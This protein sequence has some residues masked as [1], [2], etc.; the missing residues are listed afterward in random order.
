MIIWKSQVFVSRNGRNVPIEGAALK[1]AYDLL[2]QWVLKEKT[3]IPYSTLMDS[4]KAKNHR[5]I[6][7]GSIGHIVGHIS[8]QVAIATMPKSIY[9]SSIVVLKGTCNTGDGF[10]LVDEGSNPPS[11]IASGAKKKALQT[12]QPATLNGNWHL[13]SKVA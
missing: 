12:Y 11:N 7:R 10:W 5:N 4:L 9:P 13:P 2:Y 1:D 6:Q 8:E 3:C